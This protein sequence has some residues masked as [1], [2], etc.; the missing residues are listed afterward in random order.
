MSAADAS[1]QVPDYLKAFERELEAWRT[2]CRTPPHPKI[3]KIPADEIVMMPMRDGVRLYTEVYWPRE[4]T[5]PWPIVLMRTPYP[6]TTFPFSAR[7]IEVFQDAGYAVAVQSCRGT[8]KSEGRFRLYQNEPEDG[9]DCIEWL[10]QQ[11]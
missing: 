1:R 9:F 10:A 7:P 3:S 4:G 6:D 2:V 5:K 8:W 11:V